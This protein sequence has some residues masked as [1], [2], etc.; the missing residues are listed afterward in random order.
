MNLHWGTAPCWARRDERTVLSARGD[1]PALESCIRLCLEPFLSAGPCMAARMAVGNQTDEGGNQRLHAWQL[2][3]R[4]MR[5]AI[6]LM[7]K[8]IR[9]CMHGS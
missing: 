2:A 8:A 7:R 9:G 4:L 1:E 3:N 5:E 6:R